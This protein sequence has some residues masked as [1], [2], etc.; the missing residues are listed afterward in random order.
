MTPSSLRKKGKN[1]PLNYNK[2]LLLFLL[3]KSG[4][5]LFLEKRKSNKKDSYLFRLSGNFFFGYLM[6]IWIIISSI[7]CSSSC[8]TLA[9]SDFNFRCFSYGLLA[10]NE[11]TKR[12]KN[13]HAKWENVT[14][15]PYQGITKWV[16]FPRVKTDGH[17]LKITEKVSFDIA[18][19]AS[20]VYILSGQ[21]LIKN[22][23][24][25]PF[26][27]LFENLKLEAKQCYQTGQ[28]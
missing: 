10:W 26:W 15:R 14:V 28:F 20:Y 17:C 5:R 8:L 12:A 25:S 18:S 3:S 21:K 6:M 27:R 23:Q 24:N 2:K 11:K 19:E 7:I 13:G 1:D 16:N 9:P 22:A 4:S